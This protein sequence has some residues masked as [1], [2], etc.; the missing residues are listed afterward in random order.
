MN[1]LAERDPVLRRFERDAV[2]ACLLLAGVALAWPWGGPWAAASVAGG[3]L[4]AA[5][6]YRAT[7]G[8]VD[9][10]SEGGSRGGGLV[11]YFTRYGIL[12]VAAYVMLARLRLHP[13]GVVAG[14]SSLVIAAG[15]AALRLL[16]SSSRSGH[17]RF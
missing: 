14:A 8:G 3:G 7:K 2:L 4:L 11:K 1:P 17:P 10:L 6:S 16:W 15:M 13:V 12:A 5:A 9:A